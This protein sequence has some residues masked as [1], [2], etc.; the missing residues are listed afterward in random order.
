MFPASVY[1]ES[2]AANG[3]ECANGDILLA[4]QGG[5]L[6]SINSSSLLLEEAKN[7]GFS[8][9]STEQSALL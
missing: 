4:I 7:I 2:D 5:C 8:M 9:I 6:P 1:V 3:V